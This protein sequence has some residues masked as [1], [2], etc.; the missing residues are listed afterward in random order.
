MKE[1]SSRIVQS[2][3]AIVPAGGWLWL[4]GVI[5]TA[6]PLVAVW[7]PPFVA[8][9]VQAV[10][11]RVFLPLCHQLPARS[12]HWH[13]VQLAVCDRCTGLYTGI[14]VGACIAPWIRTGWQRLGARRA[15]WVLLGSGALLGI[16]WLLPVVGVW[17][18]TM[19][20]RYATGVIFG[21]VASSY[22]WHVLAP[23]ARAAAP[24]ESAPRC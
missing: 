13:G 14:F 24:P 10:L 20:G 1:A 3:W 6:L 5:A 2:Q 12:I 22:V 4:G 9:E 23:P 17:P 11:M 8:P 19:L 21:S 16:H 18:G 7:L 15:S